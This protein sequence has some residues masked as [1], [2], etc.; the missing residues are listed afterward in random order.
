MPFLILAIL[1]G[2]ETYGILQ[3]MKLIGGGWTLLL[4]LLAAVAG[5]F[6]ITR[7]GMLAVRRIQLAVARGELPAGE[8]FAGLVAAFA[9]LLLILP[10]FVT[11]VVAFSLLV[12]GGGIQR[13]LG[14]KLSVQMGQLRPDLKRPVTLEGEYRQKPQDSLRK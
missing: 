3:A 10:G 11:D 13:R 2:V 8:V 7:G 1:V 5:F 12:G 14:D 9:G 6:V 4:L